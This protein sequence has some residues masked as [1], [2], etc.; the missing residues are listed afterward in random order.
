MP[1][2][3]PMWLRTKSL[4]MGF[5]LRPVHIYNTMRSSPPSFL[6]LTLKIHG[7]TRKLTFQGGSKAAEKHQAPVS[8]AH[9]ELIL[10]LQDFYMPGCVLSPRHLVNVRVVLPLSR[11]PTIFPLAL[12]VWASVPDIRLLA[13]AYK[14][15]PWTHRSHKGED[16]HCRCGKPSCGFL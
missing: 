6:S 15:L 13:N 8:G 11:K 3:H 12:T 16:R 1:E 7:G 14:F 9:V 5:S 2:D 10:R 4:H